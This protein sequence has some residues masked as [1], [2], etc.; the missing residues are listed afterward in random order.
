[1]ELTPLL[2]PIKVNPDSIRQPFGHYSHGICLPEGCGLLLTSGQLG[3]SKD[4]AT[5]SSVIEQA[6][7]C[8][9]NIGAILEAQNLNFDHVIKINA[10]VTSRDYFPDYMAVRDEFI[11]Q[12]IASTL[13]IVGGFTRAEFKVEVE[14][15]AAFKKS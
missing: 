10:Y 8:F 14:A 6:R 1:M 7:I 2:E 5:P 9:R 15:I 4:D 13:L 11:A 3:T 12:P